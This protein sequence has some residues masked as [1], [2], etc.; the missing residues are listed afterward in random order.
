[1]SAYLATQLG[2]LSISLLLLALAV[3]NSLATPLIV[4]GLMGLVLLRLSATSGSWARRRSIVRRAAR[5]RHTR[6]DT[7]GL[8][9]GGG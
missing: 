5:G 6:E 7:A 8:N 1:M 2:V 9:R 4:V 3:R